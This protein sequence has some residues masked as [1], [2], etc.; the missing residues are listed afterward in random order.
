[1]DKIRVL[2]IFG[3]RPEAVKMAPVVHLLSRTPDI[4]SHICVTAQHR[5]MLDQ[6]L[7]LFE[8]KPDIDLNLMQAN[9][10]LADLTANIFQSL[11]PVLSD[12]DPQWI[13]VQGDTTTVMAAAL[14]AFYHQ[15]K[16]G[17]VEAGLRTE[18]KYAPFP[19]EINRRVASVVADLN[20]APTQHSRQNLLREGV[21]DWRIKVTGN[22]VIDAL[23]EIVKFPMPEEIKEILTARK[24]LSEERQL[25]TITAHRRESFGKPIED[26][27]HALRQIALDFT[28]K[29][30]L[31]YPVHLNPNIQEPVHRILD[32]IPNITL[33]KPI[34]YLPLVHL[35]KHSKLVLTDSGG[36]QEE[37]TGLGVPTLV[38]REVT[39]RP[40]GV[41]AG[42]LKLVGTD[43]NRIVRETEH[44]LEDESSYRTMAHAANPFGDGHASEKI[45]K[46]I[47]E[48]HEPQRVHFE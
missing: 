45:V 36:I 48:Y 4:E 6:V 37:A 34:E 14:C 25:I 39:E 47:L 43:S 13:L 26:I 33:L 42:V 28:G 1:M 35:L 8:I 40:E 10:E 7:H 30:E 2:S 31:V 12:I 46:A 27:C 41:E 9:Q 24:V 5:E 17:H 38:L 20:F 44:L 3:T 16:V 15:I 22:T 23:Q 18:N 19:E 29:L 21:E 32:G 11:D